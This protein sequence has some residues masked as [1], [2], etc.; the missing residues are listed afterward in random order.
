MLP[1]RSWTKY[2]S[3]FNIL[4]WI[5]LK[6]TTAKLWYI[7]L[8]YFEL[9]VLS[10]NGKWPIY[11]QCKE[12]YMAYFEPQA[13]QAVNA[14]PLRFV[15]M[16]FCCNG[17][18]TITT[19]SNHIHCYIFYCSHWH[20][21]A[22]SITHCQWVALNE[23]MNEWQRQFLQRCN[24]HLPSQW[25]FNKFNTESVVGPTLFWNNNVFRLD[26]NK[27]VPISLGPNVTGVGSR[28]K[29]RGQLMTFSYSRD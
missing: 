28:G 10:N 15:I 4:L 6:K 26:V 11:D 16:K 20:I 5:N 23:G 13:Y 14:G 8:Q 29:A 18:Y 25:H 24:M 22:H 1:D 9:P 21:C 17:N 27:L 12:M 3:Y 7:E 2:N 19:L